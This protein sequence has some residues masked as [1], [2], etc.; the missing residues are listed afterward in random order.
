[1]TLGRPLDPFALCPVEGQF[2]AIHRKEVLTEEFAQRR[3]Q[4]PEPPQ[5]RIVA[6][7][8][9]TRLRPVDNPQHN[10][11]KDDQS[12]HSDKQERQ[13]IQ[14]IHGDAH[15]DLTFNSLHLYEGTR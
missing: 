12:D 6:P 2:F 15:N 5:H 13:K 9:I 8:G 10:R 4:R 1:M 3:K 14:C 11:G 7:D